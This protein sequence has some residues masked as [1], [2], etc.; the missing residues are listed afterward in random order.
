[1]AIVKS[2]K[3]E[4]N[5]DLKSGKGKISLESGVLTD[6]AYGFN[7]R[8]AGE[9]GTNPEELLGAAHASCFSMALSNKLS[10]D[11][12]PPEY[13]RTEDKVHLEKVGEG[14]KVT[15]IEV[16]TEASVPGIDEATFLEAANFAKAN[17]PISLALTGTEIVLNA[18]FNQ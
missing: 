6:A 12:H 10:T 5:G 3:V 1:M 11:G 2:A 8:F 13:I 14:F 16:N 17:C 4:W 7:T 9:K 18:K 15:K